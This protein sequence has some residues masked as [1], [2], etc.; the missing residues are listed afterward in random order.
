M[1][2]G[3]PL[4]CW[5]DWL[6]D[7]QP[8]F[9]FREWSTENLCLRTFILFSALTLTPIHSHLAHPQTYTQHENCL[10]HNVLRQPINLVR[11][12]ETRAV[13][14]WSGVGWWSRQKWLCPRTIRVEAPIITNLPISWSVKSPFS[15]SFFGGVHLPHTHPRCRLFTV[16]GLRTS[17]AF[18][19]ETVTILAV[20]L[21]SCCGWCSFQEFA[22]FKSW[23][24]LFISAC[25]SVCHMPCRGT[26]RR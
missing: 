23:F 16:F 8:A 1:E 25:S 21:S 5:F 14:K 22:T 24:S 7:G 3:Y 6:A 15:S 26:H 9:H 2:G 4:H 13:T 17:F 10:A 12:C 19:R 11:G 20:V 18:K